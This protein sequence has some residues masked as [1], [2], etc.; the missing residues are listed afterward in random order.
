[1]KILNI[2]IKSSIDDP[3]KIISLLEEKNARFAG[4]D[5]QIDT[6]FSAEPGRLKLRQG[7]IENTLIYYVRPESKE[8]KRSE[9]KIQLLS[10]ENE[11]LRTIL[12][13]LHG[14]KAIVDKRRKIYFIDNVKFHVDEVKRL[15]SFVEIEAA[16]E[17]G[18]HA[19]SY[20]KEQCEF[21]IEYLELDREK[22]IDRSYSDL[23]LELK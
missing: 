4:E 23:V 22:F 14:I 20:L 16:D 7:N 19:E 6:Y 5:H 13:V 12:E 18:A 10:K 17:N 1:M 2:E 3:E 11:G 15:G 21:Y 9:V 8:L